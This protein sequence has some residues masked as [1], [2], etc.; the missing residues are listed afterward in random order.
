[1]AK[2]QE[3][4]ITSM[5]E[6]LETFNLKI[7]KI[8]CKKYEPLLWK[9]FEDFNAEVQKAIIAKMICNRTDMLGTEAHKK[10]VQWLKDH[11]M[12]GRVF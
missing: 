7:F 10:A 8:W 9:D 3:K 1:M 2:K 6:A 11:N 5:K 12:K 4:N